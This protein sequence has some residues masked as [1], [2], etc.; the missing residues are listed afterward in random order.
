MN[1]IK[2]LLTGLMIFSSLSCF[3]TIEDVYK[4]SRISPAS[5]SS[6]VVTGGTLSPGFNGS[7]TFYTV[8]VPQDS[9]TVTVTA[10]PLKADTTLRY[11]IDSAE[12]APYTPGQ[13]ISV[14]AGGPAVVLLIEVSTAGGLYRQT[15]TLTII[16]QGAADA[17]LKSISVD[18]QPLEG[19][20]AGI[21]EYD[22]VLPYTSAGA[23]IAAETNTPAASFRYS[24]DGGTGWA[25]GANGVA[26]TVNV[27]AGSVTVL[28]IEVTASDNSTML[29]YTINITRL[30][31]P[32][33]TLASLTANGT[34]LEFTGTGCDLALEYGTMVVAFVPVTASDTATM[35]YL[36]DGVDLTAIASG[37]TFNVNVPDPYKTVVLQIVVTSADLSSTAT[38][39]VNI[40]RKRSW[41]QP[42]IIDNVNYTASSPDIAMN[43]EGSAIVAWQ[44]QN[45]NLFEN[46]YANIYTPGTGWQETVSIRTVDSAN[47]LLP[48]VT[49][50]GTTAF[51]IWQTEVDAVKQIESRRYINS[52]W[53]FEEVMVWDALDPIN[54]SIAVDPNGIAIAVWCQN[55]GSNYQIGA[56]IY[57]TGAENPGWSNSYSPDVSVTVEAKPEIAFDGSGNAIAVWKHSDNAIYADRYIFNT[58]PQAGT[59]VQISSESGTVQDPRIAMNSNGTACVIWQQTVGGYTQI[60][61]NRYSGSWQGSGRALTL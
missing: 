7:T 39:T 28:L 46:I 21:Y 45:T 3:N 23:G 22:L 33:A 60:F 2:K 51:V 56:R 25:G 20:T 53:E 44:H 26:V 32:D 31:S 34:A 35:I 9:S 43:S 58:E 38:Y 50:N 16:Q 54:P 40:I 24:T 12:W 37:E 36:I 27:A 47:C 61:T 13:K 4:E 18:G 11:R 49:Y 6:L 30:P 17:T 8:S 55:T 1:N 10:L 48:R 15:Y 14:T 57:S 59:A 19:F 42:V 5:L 29:T 41:G 52:T